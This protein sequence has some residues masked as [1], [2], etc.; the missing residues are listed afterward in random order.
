MKEKTKMCKKVDARGITLIALIITIIVM[1]IL[2]AVTV[3]IALNGGLIGKTQEA[4]RG[5]RIGMVKDMVST[6]AGAKQAENEGEKI[7]KSQLKEILDRYF[8][9]VPDISS[10]TDEELQEV[11]LT[12]KEEYGNYSNIPLT[13]IYSGTTS[14]ENNNTIT[15]YIEDVKYTCKEGTTWK[16][17]VEEDPQAIALGLEIVSEPEEFSGL[18]RFSGKKV[19]CTMTG[20]TIEPSW[21]NVKRF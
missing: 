3:R 15:F 11:K 13:E 21:E 6:D 1:L 20:T 10:M 18:V 19:V 4:R 12:L 14:T 2:V 17:F 5:T 9:E 7:S 8:E 16:Q